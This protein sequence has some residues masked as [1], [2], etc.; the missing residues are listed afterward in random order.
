MKKQQVTTIQDILNRYWEERAKFSNNGN[1]TERSIIRRLERQIPTYK[2]LTS[3]TTAM[4]SEFIAKRS[5]TV[6]PATINRE[7]TVIETAW[8]MARDVWDLPVGKLRWKGLKLPVPERREDNSLSLSEAMMLID[9]LNKIEAQHI[10]QA[11]IWSIYTGVRLNGT[12]TLLWRHVN[13]NEGVANILVKRKPGL[14]Q[15]RWRRI[16]LSAQCLS[17]LNSMGKGEPDEAVF[18]LTNRQDYWERGRAAI[19]REDVTWH[20]LR[21]THADFLRRCGATVEVVQKSLGH[22]NINTT[23]RYLFVQDEEVSEALERMPEL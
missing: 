10:S 3:L 20:G 22:E 23:M 18:D 7:L 5:L 4:V 15:E 21:H 16:R 1:N 17:L 14:R 12:R 13:L 8:T 9:A 19:G 6:K 11:V 2:P